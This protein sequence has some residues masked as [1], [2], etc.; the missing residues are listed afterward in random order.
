MVNFHKR[1]HERKEET[2]NIFSLSITISGTLSV[3]VLASGKVHSNCHFV[4]TVHFNCSTD[5]KNLSCRFCSL[6]LHQYVT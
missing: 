6:P 1:M 2:Y 3:E 5:F 4:S